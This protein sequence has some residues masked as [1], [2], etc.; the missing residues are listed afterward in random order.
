MP[1]S[2]AHCKYP[3][4][5]HAHSVSHS[6][7]FVWLHIGNPPTQSHDVLYAGSSIKG[8]DETTTLETFFWAVWFQCPVCRMRLVVCT[9]AAAGGG[10]LVVEGEYGLRQ[11]ITCFTAPNP[12]IWTAFNPL[13]FHSTLHK[14]QHILQILHSAQNPL[15][16]ISFSKLSPPEMTNGKKSAAA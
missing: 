10:E 8:R 1:R 3:G 14:A 4:T 2:N 12:H 5:L 13:A 7:N 15:L 16:Y 11:V 9:C 6:R